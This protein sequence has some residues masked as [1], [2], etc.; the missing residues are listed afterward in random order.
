MR[1]KLVIGAM[2]ALLLG[3]AAALA[4]AREAKTP[5]REPLRQPVRQ[6]P[7]RERRPRPE[8]PERLR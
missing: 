4:A 2:A 3:G 6:L 5:E 1:K 8:P 7:L